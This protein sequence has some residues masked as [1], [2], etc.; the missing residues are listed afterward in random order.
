MVRKTQQFSAL[1]TLSFSLSL[2]HLAHPRFFIKIVEMERMK[3][4]L[5]HVEN[6]SDGNFSFFYHRHLSIFLILFGG[7]HGWKERLYTINWDA[8]R[9]V[10]ISTKAF[11]F[12]SCITLRNQKSHRHWSQKRMLKRQFL[13]WAILK[14]SLMMISA[15]SLLLPHIF[16]EKVYFI[17]NYRF[18][19]MNYAV[20]LACRSCCC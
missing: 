15:Y 20:L 13:P 8:Q 9:M 18:H 2:S 5:V 3:P 4:F 14:R 16:M 7:E 10:N 6:I 12:F 1:L 17:I 11:N 19:L